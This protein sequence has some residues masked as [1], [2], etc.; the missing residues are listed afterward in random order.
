MEESGGSSGRQEDA[1]PPWAPGEATVFR[2]FAAAT[3]SGRS[4]EA[5]PSASG[6]GAASRISSLHGVRRKSFVARL[7][8]GIIQTYQQ[9]DPK[10]KYTDDHN[11]KRYLTSPSIPAHNDGLDNA[12]WDLILYVNLELVN[13]MSNRRFIVKEMLG[14]GTFGQVV[15]C[16]DTETNDYVAVKV[17]KN[18][19]AFYHQAI[20]EVSLLR[21][22]NQKFDPDDQH[23]IV[24]MLDYL[25]FQNHLCIAF[26][27]LGQNLYELLK[28]NQLRGLKVKYVQAFS[29]QILEAMVVMRDAGIIHCDLK[30]ENIL[31]APSVTT[32]AAVKV[33]DFGSACLEGKTVYSYI[34]SRYY[35]SPEVLLGYPYTTAIDMWSFGCIV[36]ELFIGLPLFPGASEYDVLQRM[37]TIL[38]GQ[39]PDDLL[40]EA[41][42]TGRFFKHVGSIF[43]GSEIPDGIASAY[44][45]LC[46]DEIEARESKRPK[47]GKWYFP[48]LKLDRLICTYPWNKSE[49]TETEKT[50]RLALVD[51]LKGLLEFDPNKRWSPLQA[52]YHPF[53]TGEPFTGPYEPVPETARI[54]VARAAAIDHNPGGGHWLHSGL[55]P[56]VGSV[57][58]WLPLNNAYPPRMPFSY[59]SSYGSFG[60]HG[61]Y[62]G[63]AGFA[64]S[65]GSI[66]DANTMNMYYSPLG[67]SGFTQIGSSPDIRLRPRVPHDRGIRLSPGSL[68]PM[69]LGASPSQ[70]T[71][72]NYQ[73]QI[74][75]N[76]TG[77]HVSGSPASGGIH[78]S[79]LGKAA[80][81]GPYNMRR[82]FPMPP[83]DYASQHGQGRYGDGVSF[84]HS[85][86]YVRGHT[87]HS[88][89]AGPSSGHSS[90][91]P[92]I[93][94]RSG[95]SLEASS[96]R[97]PSHVHHP[98]AP[99]HSF[100]FSPNTS[101]PSAL[102]PADWDPNYSDES[103]LQEDS[104]LSADLSS[105][106]HLGEPRQPS[107][108]TRSANFQGHVF[109][110][111]NPVSTNQR[112]DQVFHSS[113]QG[114]SSHSNVP[115]NYGGYNPPSYPQQNPRH[116]QPIHQQRYNQANS[117]PMRPMGNH[118]SGQPVWS[119]TYGMGDGVPWGGTGGHSFTTSGLPSSVGRKDYGSI[120]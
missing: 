6:N 115:I 28:R 30:P 59:G 70:F 27:M 83:H 55:S 100:D 78:G 75:P 88:Q 8:A 103:L 58:R 37:M 3:A 34:Q 36:A 9:C 21:T 66:G 38:G 90:W 86:G 68:G 72:P 80:A 98:Q 5:T 43:P 76:S 46:E 24:R 85:D 25:S 112:G 45:I 81:A 82:N 50:D 26:E 14:Q 10:F 29:K 64:N 51:F 84:S 105:S 95:F 104:S 69:S 108:S 114:G 101:A 109:A 11:P 52:L 96:S 12:N 110:T 15:K 56:Q 65:Y 91:R 118:H 41:K 102:D 19:P 44:R 7:T 116:G 62:T 13:K 54:P 79:P 18:Q 57:N 99:S 61:S 92:Q 33:I 77:K 113:Y 117:G 107:G 23:N 53:I 16:W 20:M 97:G 4:T 120:F 71:P 31:L 40:R 32:A 47:V 39:P 111:S 119:S 2:R 87:G 63:N 67:S 89:N 73:M 74:P 106:L 94:S 17:I 60:S 42:N 48:R 1:A 49:L 93:S 22:L 35:R